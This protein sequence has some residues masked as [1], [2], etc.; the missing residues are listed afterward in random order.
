VALLAAWCLG[1]LWTL[2]TPG[3][4]EQLPVKTY[5]TAAGLARDSI[6][7]IVQDSHGFLWF[8]TA[9]GLSRFDGYRFTNYGTE[10]GLP[11][12]SIN[13][14]LETRS[15]VYW[16]ATSDG[17][18]LF[19]P[20]GIGQPKI[21]LRTEEAPTSDAAAANSASMFVVYYPGEAKRSRIITALFEDHAGGVWCGTAEGLYR[22]EHQDGIWKSQ[23]VD[24]GPIAG[25]STAPYITSF[26]EDR[27][28]A[29]WI[30]ATSGLCK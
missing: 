22:L 16:I 7:R 4:A 20:N 21:S 6:N 29:L 17:L 3:I 18:C 30:G 11:H 25:T 12:R 26:H 8:A 2:A 13:D 14:V 5:T 23:P 28:G 15:G 24:I 27:D 9:E 1:F 10:Q 19:N